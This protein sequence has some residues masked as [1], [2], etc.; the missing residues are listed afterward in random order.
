MAA[1][2]SPGLKAIALQPEYGFVNWRTYS[3]AAVLNEAWLGRVED[4]RHIEGTK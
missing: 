1:G 2:V 4:F 3:H